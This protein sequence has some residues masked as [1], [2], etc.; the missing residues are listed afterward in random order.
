MSL[1]FRSLVPP[2]LDG[3]KGLPCCSAVLIAFSYGHVLRDVRRDKYW[4]QAG[5]DTSQRANGITA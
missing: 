5:L 2:A 3:Q 1:I 4:Y